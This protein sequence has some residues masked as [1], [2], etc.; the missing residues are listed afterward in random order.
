MKAFTLRNA[1]R[2]A[3]LIIGLM[4]VA[5]ASLGALSMM[6]GT[7]MQERLT[8]NQQNKIIA[9]MAAEAGAGRFL[10]WVSDAER[11]NDLSVDWSDASQRAD[12]PNGPMTNPIQFP[13][14]GHFFIPDNDEPDWNQNL[15]SVNVTGISRSGNDILSETVLNFRFSYEGSEPRG[16]GLG[17]AINFFGKVK[18]FEG[19]NSNAYKVDGQGGPAIGTSDKSSK[20][21]IEKDIRDKGRLNN[22]TG[23]IEEIAYPEP[24][25]NPEKLK[26]FVDAVCATANY[27]GNLAPSFPTGQG[28]NPYGTTSNRMVNVLTGNQTIRFT[29]NNRGAGVL[30]VTGTLTFNGTPSW[31][32]VIIV[33]GGAVH[34]SGGGNGGLEGTMFVTNIDT[35]KDPW[36]FKKE[37]KKDENG[38]D[39]EV[40]VGSQF[41]VSGGGNV[42]YNFDCDSITASRN[43]LSDAAKNIW[44]MDSCEGGGGG[45]SGGSSNRGTPRIVSWSEVIP[46]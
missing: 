11:S 19:A 33:L 27:C 34:T 21:A 14:F 4:L 6:R 44:A 39:V 32:G 38:N 17:G 30:I 13:P 2:G 42:D 24:W 18:T 22:Y 23:G 9:N 26:D 36:R 35:S 5:V 28:T 41:T 3:A 15:I 45:S 31:D 37:I 29:G 7:I 1:Q 40:E 25:S 46:D 10:E 43:L 8:S 20:D 12:I 16:G